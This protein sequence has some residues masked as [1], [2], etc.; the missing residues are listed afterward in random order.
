MKQKYWTA[1]ETDYLIQETK[2]GTKPKIIAYRLQKKVDDIYAQR[3]RIGI[4]RPKWNRPPTPDPMV[5][6][7]KNQ[8]KGGF[9]PKEAL[10]KYK[11]KR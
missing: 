6:I 1:K 11:T 2:N 8:I 5:N 10:K 9:L 4:T 3:I 7:I